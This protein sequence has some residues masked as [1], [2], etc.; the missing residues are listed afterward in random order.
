MDLLLAVWEM[1]GFF[2]MEILVTLVAMMDLHA[3][4]ALIECVKMMEPGVEQM[5]RV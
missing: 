4:V 1:M 3:T 2:L 5:G